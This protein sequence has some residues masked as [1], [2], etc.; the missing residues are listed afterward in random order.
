MLNHVE[1]L[2]NMVFKLKSQLEKKSIPKALSLNGE[3]KKDRLIN[4]LF[5]SQSFAYSIVLSED[6]E[7]QLYKEKNFNIGLKLIDSE[8]NFIRNCRFIII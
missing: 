7:P 4:L 1:E 6:F 2:E 3:D 5:K 8:S